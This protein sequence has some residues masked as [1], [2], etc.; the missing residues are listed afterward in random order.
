MPIHR[1]TNQYQG[2]NAHLHSYFQQE[3]GWADFHQ[4][5]ITDLRRALQ[6]E[7]P[8]S[9]GYFVT[10]EDSLQIGQY[11]LL[12]RKE[13]VIQTRPDI[14][15]YR[16]EVEPSIVMSTAVAS[17]PTILFP[18]VETLIEVDSVSS[19]LIYRRTGNNNQLVT[20]LEV[21]SPANK[22]PGSHYDNYFA[23]RDMTLRTGINLVEVDYLHERRSPVNGI[24]DYTQQKENSYPYS[25]TV[26]MLPSVDD[27]GETRVYAWHVDETLPKV[28]IPLAKDE[29]VVLDFEK[30]YQQTYLGN[31]LYAGLWVDYEQVPR[32]FEAYSEDDKKRIKTVM[33]RA[34]KTDESPQ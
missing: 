3:G 13:R 11:D 31:T 29:Y 1:E 12:T 15:I 9:S 22:P 20:R 16:S 33:E 30:V 34:T 19:L 10:A 18:T 28:P 25:I 8:I 24:P 21:L 27:F 23:K 5:H 32:N 14:G 26:G 17:P 7:L 4:S 2:I 6:I